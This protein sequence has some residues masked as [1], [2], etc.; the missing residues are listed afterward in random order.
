MHKAIAAL[1]P[2]AGMIGHVRSGRGILLTGRDGT[3]A[4]VEATAFDHFRG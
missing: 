4:P 1:C 2:G 3:S